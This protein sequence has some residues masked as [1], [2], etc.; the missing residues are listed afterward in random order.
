MP[1][2]QLAYGAALAICLT[3]IKSIS[4]NTRSVSGVNIFE[5]IKDMLP[6]NHIDEK[7]EEKQDQ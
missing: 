3:E 6:G 2:I 7:P 1:G 4:E 5:Q